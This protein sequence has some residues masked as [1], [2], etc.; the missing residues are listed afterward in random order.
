MAKT[1]PGDRNQADPHSGTDYLVHYSFSPYQN[2]S[3]VLRF[4]QPPGRNQLL[5]AVATY[6]VVPSQVAEISATPVPALGTRQAG[7]HQSVASAAWQAP[8]ARLPEQPAPPRH[9][10]ETPTAKRGRLVPVLLAILLA[11]FLGAAAANSDSL[12]WGK[13]MGYSTTAE[14]TERFSHC[15]TQM[16]DQARPLD[17]LTDLFLSPYPTDFPITPPNAAFLWGCMDTP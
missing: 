14:G 10:K 11:A 1:P 4:P 3:L 8:P 2:G 5:E 16:Q 17:S 12:R 15:L 13:V 6:G 9:Q 7:R